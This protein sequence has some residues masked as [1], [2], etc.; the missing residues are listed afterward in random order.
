MGFRTGVFATVWSV[1]RV[2]DTLTKARISV[3]RKDRNTGNYEQDFGGFV[4]FVGT[5]CAKRALGLKERDRIKLGDVDVTNRYD[6]AKNTTYT[7]FNVYG[8]EMAAGSGG[9]GQ[10]QASTPAPSVDDGEL[11]EELPF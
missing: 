1:E 3:S 11:S 10:T 2:S 4:A 5:A 7:N 6:K 8:F 9:S